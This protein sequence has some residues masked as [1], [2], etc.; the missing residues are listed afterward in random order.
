MD[1]D[2]NSSGRTLL[3]GPT[4]GS[5]QR[6]EEALTKSQKADLTLYYAEYQMK[7]SEY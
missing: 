4:Q 6:I 7:E 1:H 2:S 5:R 3:L